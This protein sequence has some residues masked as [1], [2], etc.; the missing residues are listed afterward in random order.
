M[1][2][3]SPWSLELTIEDP[4]QPDVRALLEEHLRDMHATSPP[5]SVH[6]LD[7]DAL[8]R[9]EVTFWCARA[10]GR[11]L[12][13]GALKE[14]GRQHG[15]LKSMRT[16]PDARNRGI[17]RAVLGAII[18]EAT[19]RRYLRLSLETGSQ[20]YFEAARQM[21]RSHGFTECGPFGPY[22][23]DPNSVF[24]TLDLGAGARADH[25]VPQ[26]GDAAGHPPGDLLEHHAG[27]TV[28]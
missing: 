11:L 27:D 15:E 10:D 13:C 16:R 24:M 23:A 22:V 12:G 1:E 14:L 4:A 17:A 25:A 3:S 20:S 26:V 5:E 8:R 21:Y 7:V 6:A 19:R 18:D 2:S 9:H 28:E